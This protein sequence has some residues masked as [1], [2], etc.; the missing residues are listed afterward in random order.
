M[1]YSMLSISH[2]TLLKTDQLIHNFL[3]RLLLTL[4]Q[5][6]LLSLAQKF[7]K[8]STNAITA[9]PQAQIIY[10]GDISREYYMTKA[11]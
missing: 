3:R 1:T 4:Q 9:L 2:I 5:N 7:T 8:H 11:A 10:H 6:G